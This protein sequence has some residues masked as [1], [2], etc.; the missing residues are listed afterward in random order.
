MQNGVSRINCEQM[1]LKRDFIKV[2]TNEVN[3]V[4]VLIW[5][6]RLYRWFSPFKDVLKV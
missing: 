6:V 3:P 5:D 1:D 4:S 2:V